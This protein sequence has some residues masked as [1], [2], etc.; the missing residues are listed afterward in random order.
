MRNPWISYNSNPFLFCFFSAYR[1]QS[2]E[3]NYLFPSDNNF[4]I[5]FG[6]LF[7]DLPW[8]ESGS[9]HYFD[10]LDICGR[11]IGTNE[12]PLL[13]GWLPCLRGS[14]QSQP[15][16][17]PTARPCGSAGSCNNQ[18]CINLTYLYILSWPRAGS[19][20][21]LKLFLPCVILGHDANVVFNN[22]GPKI[23]PP[24]RSTRF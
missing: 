13:G 19:G 6:A 16:R 3:Q 21:R 18:D 5:R 4:N 14:P 2:V 24:A 20:K 17:V 1:Y 23:F 9:E 10:I 15:Q 7:E 12:E 8:I 22:P 11:L